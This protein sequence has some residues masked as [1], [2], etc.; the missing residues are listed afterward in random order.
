MLV[1]LTYELSDAEGEVV[2]ASED[3]APLEVLL[4]YGD[5]A[6]AFERALDGLSRG[7]SREVRIEPKDGFG[8]RDP[9]GFIEV[10][11]ADLPAELEPG[12]ELVAER[13]T[14]GVIPLK[15]VEVTPDVVVLDTNHPLAGQKVLLRVAVVSV[16]PAPPEQ[17]A[18]A[19][20]RLEG[21][22]DDGLVRALL[23]AERLLRRKPLS[24]HPEDEPPPGPSRVA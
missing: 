2:E 18:V 11:R 24:V 22:A 19:S 1:T 17:I 20:K 15:V 4:G 6:P 3:G 21:G 9:H 10:D 12:D 8:K 5:V 14:G 13:D 7:Q 16:R 23:P